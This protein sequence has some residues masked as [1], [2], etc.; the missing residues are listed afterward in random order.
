MTLLT[1]EA[2]PWGRLSI[3]G[4]CCEGV[5]CFRFG[6]SSKDA[7]TDGTNAGAGALTTF[8]TTGACE[9]IDALEAGKA[10]IGCDDDDG[11]DESTAEA[12]LKGADGFA[13]AGA[14]TLVTTEAWRV[15]GALRAGGA[16]M[17][18][19]VDDGNTAIDE[20]AKSVGCCCHPKGAEGFSADA[21]AT[22]PKVMADV[23]IDVIGAAFVVAAVNGV[24]LAAMGVVPTAVISLMSVAAVAVPDSLAGTSGA[25][26]SDTILSLKVLDLCNPSKT[27]I[28]SSKYS[29]CFASLNMQS[30]C[31]KTSSI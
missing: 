16:A 22:T 8:V 1:A 20:L 31:R 18:C 14:A 5:S 23:C 27:C 28:A 24:V 4:G 3:S 29:L 30:R 12:H 15:M 19:D 17:G 2:D 9:A 21:N 26:K 7:V 10:A 13:S 25:D 6:P 11:D